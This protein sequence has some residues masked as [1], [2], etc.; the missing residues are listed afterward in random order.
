GIE[1]DMY[2]LQLNR[3]RGLIFGLLT[4][5][6][7]L[8]IG[9]PASIYLLHLDLNT[10]ILLA[11]MYASHTLIAYPVT[12]RYGITKSPA[13][14][15]AIVGTII[16]VI[17]ALLVLAGTVS[18][19]RTGTFGISNISMLILRLAIYCALTLYLYP[20][21]TRWF[22]R[23]FSD[24]VT[25][26][27]FVMA[28]VFLS[29]WSAQVIGLE[30]VLG[31]FFAGLVLNRFVPN[32]S[33]LMSRIE[34]VGNALFIPY[35]LIGVG[36]MIDIRVIANIDTLFVAFNMI[37]VALVAKWLAAWLAQKIYGM[38]ADSRQVMFG[39]ST[40]HTA[41]ALAV[42]TIGY[43]MILPD[44][45]RMMDKTILNGTVLMI[46]VTCAIAPIVT[47][48]ASAR[49]RRDMLSSD[50]PDSRE[51]H[52]HEVTNTLIAMGNPLTAQGLADLAL[53]M[54]PLT[55]TKQIWAAHVR[56]DN[57]TRARAQ[58][59]ET[60]ETAVS[61]GASVDIPVTPIERFDL[62]TVTGLVN[63]MNEHDI[64]Q[65]VLGMHRKTTVIDTFL[66]TKI[67][68]ILKSCNRMIV[69]ARLYIPV[70]TARRMVVWAPQMT[71][72]ETGFSLWVT[73]IGNLARETGCKLIICC[74]PETKPYIDAELRS[75]RIAVRM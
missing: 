17:G 50:S 62:S 64:H 43:N 31:A 29:A 30:P 14:L 60:I 20:R 23:S 34:F 71:E 69:I 73:A 72:F 55:G 11:S 22:F 27:V 19:Q 28:L 48:R 18:V 49:I 4:F 53:L 21:V 32:S 2:H 8:A 15:I 3:R 7:P 41:V 12:A 45:N 38:N 1:L 56:N 42:V 67:E 9:I 39:L 16:A 65:M 33:P 70:N 13:V 58:G 26:Y 61:A 35:F 40:A 44:G 24:R 63:I 52:N 37:T 47:A 54:Q 5:L 36:M 75:Q 10:S 68:Q 57:S 6:L 51:H 66:G 25:Q 59:R 46:L 74:H